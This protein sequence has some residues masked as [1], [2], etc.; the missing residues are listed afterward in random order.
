MMKLTELGKI[1]CLH[2]WI[3]QLLA[4]F[5]CLLSMT[6]RCKALRIISVYANVK[7]GP[8]TTNQCHEKC[9]NN[10]KVKMQR[11]MPLKE[12]GSAI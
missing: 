3:S 6:M 10:E 12:L 2:F 5:H 11:K 8:T 1:G 7:N 4:L 9:C